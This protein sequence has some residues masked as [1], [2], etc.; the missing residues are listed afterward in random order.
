MKR[1]QNHIKYVTMYVD[2]KKV[3]KVRIKPEHEDRV[4]KLFA[5]LIKSAD[6]AG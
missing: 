4:Y 5:D 1:S 3:D 6:N 2:G